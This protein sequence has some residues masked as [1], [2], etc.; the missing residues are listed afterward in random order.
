L[1][2]TDD[3]KRVA[4]I[5]YVAD[6]YIYRGLFGSEEGARIVL[7][8]LFMDTEGIFS[9]RYISIIETDDEIIGSATAYSVLVKINIDDF[10]T[11]IF[12]LLQKIPLEFDEVS[13]YLLL[14]DNC[15]A[16]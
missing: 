15:T 7:P 14:S 12:N 1:E 2:K 9:R 8:V 16:G 11:R 3:L 4:E 10:R 6:P 5:T 13:R